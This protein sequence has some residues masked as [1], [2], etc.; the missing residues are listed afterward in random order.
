MTPLGEGG[1]QGED[2]RVRPVLR[3]PGAVELEP[4]ARS[5]GLRVLAGIGVA[6]EVG[7]DDRA[8]GNAEG[9][10]M[11]DEAEAHRP[12]LG[13][14]ADRRAGAAV[15]LGGGRED[16]PLERLQA[17]V[18]RAHLDRARADA[19][20]RDVG[21][22]PL[23]QRGRALAPQRVVGAVVGVAVDARAR[24]DV[25]AGRLRDRPQPFRIAAEVVR[26]PVD[27]RARARRRDRAR[28]R[29]RAADVRELLAGLERRHEEQMLVR[30]GR[31]QVGGLDVAEHGADDRGH[32]PST[33]PA[34]AGLRNQ[35][36]HG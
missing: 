16:R 36:F 24:D 32:L 19:R 12:V 23:R 25:Q 31:A 14:D 15:G 6:V 27:E 29:D 30:V 2:R 5:G 18:A 11:L 3:P 17:V 13:V 9:R 34:A 4:G 1:D 22:E 8:R 10:E 26:R 21:R 7:E 20:A 28:L 35:R 33:L